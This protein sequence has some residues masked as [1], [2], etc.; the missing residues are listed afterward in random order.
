M[1]PDADS[2]PTSDTAVE[3]RSW[4]IHAI[5]I[6]L[7]MAY[8]SSY[9]YLSRR[10]FAATDEYSESSLKGFFFYLPEDTAEWERKENTLRMLY[11]PLIYVDCWMGTGRWPASPPTFK[12]SDIRHRKVATE[13]T[14]RAGADLP[15][16]VLTHLFP[17]SVT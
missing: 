2:Q 5:A 10:G 13:F 12:L 6:V 11:L 7:L 4:L 9:W 8:I 14:C 3:Q 15:C 17:S 16:S 1:H